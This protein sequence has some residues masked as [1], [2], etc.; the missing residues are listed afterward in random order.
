[1]V[2]VGLAGVLVLRG[3]DRLLADGLLVAFLCQLYVVSCFVDWHGDAAFGAR[4]FIGCIPLFGLGLAAL[5]DRLLRRGVPG[6]AVGSVCAAAAAWNYL[7]L[8]QYGT[9]MIPRCGAVSWLDVAR[10]SLIV[11]P[12]RLLS[13][14]L[15]LFGG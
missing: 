1:M 13:K 7:L 8:F 15:E 2:A 3:R 5:V 4:Y 9:K 6:I 12:G 14:V 10:N 11:I